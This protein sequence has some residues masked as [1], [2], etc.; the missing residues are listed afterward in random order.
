[1]K[2]ECSMRITE[3]FALGGDCGY[4]GYHG[5]GYRKGGYGKGYGKGGYGKG[6]YYGGYKH[7]HYRHH[8]RGLLGIL[9]L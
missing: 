4:G 3:I 8:R 1:M 6:Y 9:Y 7:G 5:K 2:G